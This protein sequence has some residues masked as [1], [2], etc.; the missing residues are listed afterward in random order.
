MERRWARAGDRRVPK[1][2]LR[3]QD[4]PATVRPYPDA[5]RMFR[6]YGRPAVWQVSI[7]KALSVKRQE[8]ALAGEKVREKGSVMDED[9]RGDSLS[10]SLNPVEGDSSDWDEI[11]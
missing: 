1:S 4:K 11:R 10:S 3:R 7:A 9:D 5:P 2:P 6:R 8:E